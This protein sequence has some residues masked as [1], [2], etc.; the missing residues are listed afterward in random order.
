MVSYTKLKKKLINGVVWIFCETEED[1]T[2][3]ILHNQNN[4]YAL[5]HGS[6]FRGADWYFASIVDNGAGPV[7]YDFSLSE[8]KKEYNNALNNLEAL[9]IIQFPERRAV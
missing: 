4:E 9:H 8:V 5:Y 6:G 1:F 7:I 2:S 3:F